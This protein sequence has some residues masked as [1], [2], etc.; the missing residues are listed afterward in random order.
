MGAK[1]GL[2]AGGVSMELASTELT[3]FSWE[4]DL[5]N[6]T[7]PLSGVQLGVCANNCADPPECK[8]GDIECTAADK[9]D[10]CKLDA[11]GCPVFKSQDCTGATSCYV[12]PSACLCGTAV[13]TL[14]DLECSAGPTQ[15][16]VCEA[17]S[18]GCTSWAV[19]SCKTSKTC[20]E[21]PALCATGSS[22]TVCAAGTKSCNAAGTAV[23]TC[24]ADGSGWDTTETCTTGVCVGGACVTCSPNWTCSAW[25]TC[26]C[27]NTQTRTCTDSNGCGTTAG[28]P[29]VSQGCDPCT[30]FQSYYCGASSQFPG[31]CLGTLYNCG[32]SGTTVSATT[33]PYGCQVAA[34]GV[35]DYCKSAPT[36]GEYLDACTPS[37][38]CT[39]YACVQ[40]Y[41]CHG[42][43]TKPMGES[44]G[45]G[46]ECCS[47]RCVGNLCCGNDSG[48]GCSI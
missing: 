22:G 2:F 44:C 6:L 48:T 19:H 32:A 20:Y 34:A 40:G 26:G 4:K 7:H 18:N 15:I 25:S 24:R 29:S 14:G 16:S 11:G 31:G 10:V 30:G 36:C 39:S 43:G 42:T 28:K 5:V 47:G 17:D 23:Q 3:L 37:S 35:D 38:C 41:C 12:N 45:S 21:D 46:G 13:C 27:N 33:C 1:F 9:A 8:L